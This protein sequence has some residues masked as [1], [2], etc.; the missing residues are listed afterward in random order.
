MNCRLFIYLYIILDSFFLLSPSKAEENASISLVV[1]T[2][3][4]F[5]YHFTKYIHWFND[6][7]TKPFYIVVLGDGE[8]YQPLREI[9][10]KKEVNQREIVVT[11]IRQIDSLKDCHILFIPDS[12]KK[13]IPEVVN[14]TRNKNILTVSDTEGLAKKG[15]AINFVIR[16]DKVRFEINSTALSDLNLRVSSQLLK[17][18]ILVKGK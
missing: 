11:Q 16:E 4:V 10:K 14:L 1:N 7:S 15:V 17:L 5:I 8:I 18:A 12:E 3:A 13:I 9:A 6:D 2:K